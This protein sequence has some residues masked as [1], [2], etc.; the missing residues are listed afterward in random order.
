MP[1]NYRKTERQNQSARKPTTARNATKYNKTERQNQSA[2]KPTTARNATNYN[3]TERQNQSARKPT[4]AR[5][6]KGT[7]TNSKGQTSTN[8]TTLTRQQMLNAVT[9]S[10]SPMGHLRQ[11]AEAKNKGVTQRQATQQAK[12][13]LPQTVTKGLE[14]AHQ[15]R[16]RQLEEK[17]DKTTDR[18]ARAAY[19]QELLEAKYP[20]SQA[21]RKLPRSQQ[22][23]IWE[24]KSLWDRGEQ[25][26]KRGQSKAGQILQDYAHQAA[27][28]QRY[29]Q[30]YSGGDGGGDVTLPELTGRD[31]TLSDEGQKQLRSYK[32]LYDYA[33]GTGDRAGMEAARTE[34]QKLRDTPGAWDPKKQR[35]QRRPTPTRQR[36]WSS[37]RCMTEA[38]AGADSSTSGKRWRGPTR[39]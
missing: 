24:A 35:R 20:M 17:L 21:D 37:R 33:K 26:K 19:R 12:A 32:L 13:T 3:K 4:T 27:E 5:S 14:K 39:R 36:C 38:A 9:G 1:T 16:V 30:G 10:A 23:E 2:R 34:A 25:L 22:R 8:R 15:Q 18:R 31:R 6:G 28:F 7:I 29:S 11:T